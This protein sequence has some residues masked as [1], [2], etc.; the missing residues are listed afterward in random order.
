MPCGWMG[1]ILEVDL[2][3]GKVGTRDSLPYIEKTLGERVLASQIAWDELPQGIDA[4]DSRNLIIIA[5]GPLTGK[6]VDTMGFLRLMDDYCA[7]R[8][9]DLCTGWPT[10]QAMIYLD[11]QENLPALERLS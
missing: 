6:L 4:F 1:K 10:T 5:T 2:S 8:N 3:M 7:A 11:M 9:W